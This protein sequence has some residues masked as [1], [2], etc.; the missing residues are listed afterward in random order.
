MITADS[1]RESVHE[2]AQAVRDA[3]A[4]LPADE[5]DELTDGLEADLFERAAEGGGTDAFGD[6][7]VYANE[8]RTSAGLPPRP[9]QPRRYTPAEQLGATAAAKWKTAVRTVRGNAFGVWLID[10][11]VSM[12][13]LWWVLRGWAV[14]SV[15][16]LLF[17]GQDYG[18]LPVSHGS[19][20]AFW[21]WL[22]LLA[23]V[24]FS[25]QWGRGRWM[26][27][28]W[29]R[30]LRVLVSVIAVIA[31]PAVITAAINATWSQS[32]VDEMTGA[33]ASTTSGMFVNGQQV[34]NIYAYDSDG[35]LI[36]NVRLY[37]QDGNALL[38]VPES[39]TPDDLLGGN[40]SDG[41]PFEREAN[42]AAPGIAGW[43]VYPLP[44]KSNVQSPPF[45]TVPPLAAAAQETTPGVS[46]PTPTATPTP[47]PTPSATPAG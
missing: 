5:V 27:G 39:S 17:W 33:A 3:L 2:F 29:A 21:Q 6:P 22:L 32:S 19:E 11:A 20:F 14:W 47:R 31:L 40:T 43:A 25:I 24:L 8:L 4:D 7:V 18:F 42:P 35:K 23:L 13:P 44:T 41:V 10:L 26:P 46:T 16:A 37:D 1:T 36:Q 34:Y 28:R 30:G 12:R 9:A 45:F 15:A 38:T